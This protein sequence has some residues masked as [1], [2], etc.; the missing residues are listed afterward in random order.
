MLGNSFSAPQFEPLKSHTSRPSVLQ[1]I[2]PVELNLVDAESC[3]NVTLSV[4][5]AKLSSA[6]LA[7]GLTHTVWVVSML[8]MAVL[9]MAVAPAGVC[10]SQTSPHRK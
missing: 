4:N 2:E 10:S 8:A 9:A 7:T 6:A 3:N 5:S 1:P